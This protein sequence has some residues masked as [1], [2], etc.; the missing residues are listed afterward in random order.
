MSSAP[1]PTDFVAPADTLFSPRAHVGGAQLYKIPIK[2]SY[3]ACDLEFVPGDRFIK[4][5]PLTATYLPLTMPGLLLC[6]PASPASPFLADRGENSVPRWHA[7]Y[8][9]PPPSLYGSSD[10]EGIEQAWAEC[11]PP[12]PPGREMGP[13]SPHAC[14]DGGSAELLFWYRRLFAARRKHLHVI[15]SSGSAN[16]RSRAILDNI[17]RQLLRLVGPAPRVAKRQLENDDELLPLHK[18]SKRQ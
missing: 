10:G 11:A 5:S 1:A 17:Q 15:P 13:G 18:R 2:D 8:P 16:A 4:P 12:A 3:K 9:T 6:P 14:I 7:Y